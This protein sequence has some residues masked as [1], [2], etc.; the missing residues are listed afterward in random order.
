MTCSGK[1]KTK[2]TVSYRKTE[3]KIQAMVSIP[4]SVNMINTRK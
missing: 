1:A 2:T 4:D 3:R